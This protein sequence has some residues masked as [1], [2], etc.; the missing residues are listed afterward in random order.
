MCGLVVFLVVVH[1][2]LY[3]VDTLCCRRSLFV[4][5]FHYNESC[6]VFLVFVV[7][8][9]AVIMFVIYKCSVMCV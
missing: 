5:V 6:T 4:K 8:L 7:K 9:Y 3:Y 1:Y 2:S